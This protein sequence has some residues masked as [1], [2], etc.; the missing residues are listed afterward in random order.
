[1]T[2]ARCKQEIPN[3][4]FNRR[5][6]SLKCKGWKRNPKALTEFAPGDLAPRFW[7][8]VDKQE[9]GCWLWT[10]DKALNGYGTFRVGHRMIMAH[11]VAYYIATGADPS[12]LFVCHKCDVHACVNPAHLFLGTHADNMRDMCRKG[13]ASQAKLT[14][15]QVA[16]IRRIYAEE[17][18]PLRRGRAK[19][20]ASVYGIKPGT[21]SAIARGSV[22]AS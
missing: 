14:L 15:Q 18:S 2:C 16:D 20:L 11:R 7:V 6:C 22:W 8:K 10:G 5:Y 19:E 12:S 4:H 21:L 9:D 17:G 1:M 13:R 3:A